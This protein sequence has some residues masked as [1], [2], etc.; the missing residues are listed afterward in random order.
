MGYVEYTQLIPSPIMPYRYDLQCPPIK[1]HRK[2]QEDLFRN[3]LSGGGWS[4][5]WQRQRGERRGRMDVVLGGK[6]GTA[7]MGKISR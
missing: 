4:L 7:G 6:V 1:R 3:R 5:E 2:S